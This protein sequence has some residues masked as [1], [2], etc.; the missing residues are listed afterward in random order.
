MA[1]RRLN[2][3]NPAEQELPKA[4]INSKS[5]KQVGRL[6]SYVKPHRGKFIAAMI[7]LFL[8]SLVGLAFPQFL[9]ALIDAAQGKQKFSFLPASLNGIGLLALVVLFAQAIISFF[10]V[11]W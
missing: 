5:L 2:S 6:L 1:R 3:G 9:G 10:R 4:K 7:C 8:S 11:I